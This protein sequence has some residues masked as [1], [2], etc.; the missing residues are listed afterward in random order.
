[1]PTSLSSTS[2]IVISEDPRLPLPL[3]MTRLRQSRRLRLR[4][5][6][7][8]GVL[9]LTMP[10]RHSATSA[11]DWVAGQRPWIDRQLAAAPPGLPLRDGASIP[12]EGVERRIVHQ[13]GNRR[14]V[15]VQGAQ[16][17]VGGPAESLPSAI[18]RWLRSLARERLS[19]ATASIA[20]EAGVTVRS[21]S[22]GDPASRWGSCSSS[23]A[24]RFSWRLI[25][26]PPE[27][28]RFVVAHEVAHRLHMDH[29]P[30]F[31]AAEE[32]LY[33]G[34]VAAARSE[35]RRLSPS[36]RAVGRG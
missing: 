13:P 1:M 12:V 18:E 14:G 36:L 27:V 10:W 26:A 32:K 28:L 6:H 23:G 24:I 34:P 4:V 5:D 35:L 30:A 29:S 31:K 20:A 11:L 7:E 8:G 2:S 22:V 9:K 3:R 33:G 19:H 25:L 16:L 15:Q 21:V 17:L